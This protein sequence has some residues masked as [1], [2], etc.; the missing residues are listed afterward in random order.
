[1]ASE[2]DSI[3]IFTPQQDLLDRGVIAYEEN[4]PLLGQVAAGFTPPGS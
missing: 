3:D 4:V 2:V 1:M